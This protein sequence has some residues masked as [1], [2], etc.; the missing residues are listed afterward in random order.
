MSL[1]LAAPD[2]E[3]RCLYASLLPDEEE[4]CLLMWIP[5]TEKRL[6]LTQQARALD[7]ARWL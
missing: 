1:A 7:T 3:P 5:P 6:F 4:R 2:L